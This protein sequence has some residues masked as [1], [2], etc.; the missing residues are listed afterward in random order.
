MWTHKWTLLRYS[1]HNVT[2]S[3]VSNGVSNPSF[4]PFNLEKSFPLFLGLSDSQKMFL[5]RVHRNKGTKRNSAG[6]LKLSRTA[7]LHLTIDSTSPWRSPR[8]I[9]TTLPK[10]IPSLGVLMTLMENTWTQSLPSVHLSWV[11]VKARVY[12]LHRF[13][14]QKTLWV[15]AESSCERP[16]PSG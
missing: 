6:S 11:H 14:P 12:R 4:P 15:G 16:R 10:E 5:C 7:S 1:R 9:N 3:I 2:V 13:R 8:A